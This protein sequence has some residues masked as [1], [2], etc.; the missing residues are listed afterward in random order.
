MQERRSGQ[1]GSWGKH[2]E[3]AW[4]NVKGYDQRLWDCYALGIVLKG[5]LPTNLLLT[6]DPAGAQDFCDRLTHEDPE[7]RMTVDNALAHPW[8]TGKPV[9]AA[10]DLL[11][12]Q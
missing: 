9:G 8:L 1:A 11:F 12:R 4:W 2:K 3:D 10:E 6:P 5:C 7:A